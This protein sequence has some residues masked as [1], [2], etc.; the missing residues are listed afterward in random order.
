MDQL[1][2]ARIQ[3]ATTSIYHFLFVPITMGMAILVAVLHTRWFRRGTPELRGILRFFGGLML[4]SISV[5]VVTGLVQEFQF[6]LN[7]SAYSRF[8][9]DVFGAPLAMEGLAAFFLESTFLGLWLF[10]FN[11][12]PRRLHLFTAWMVAVGACLSALFIIAANSWMQNPRGYAINP[13]NGRAELTSIG[14][15]FTNPIFIW[16]YIH[17]LLVALIFG[18]GML[19]AVSA[20][21]LRRRPAVPAPPAPAAPIEAAAGAEPAASGTS[22]DAPVPVEP[23]APSPFLATAKLGLLALLIGTVLQFHVGGQ[24]GIN[25]TTYQP[26]KIAAA[27]ANWTTCQPCSFSMLQI[28]GWSA[29][30]PPTKIIE[31]PHL[32]SLL[33]TGTWDGQVQGLTPLN[34]QYQQ[35]YGPG[36]YV[37]NVFIQYWSMRV[38]AYIA[39]LVALFCVWGIWLW[40]RKKLATARLFLVVAS[41]IMVTP[42]FM[43]TAGWLLTESGR[44]P[45]IVQGLMLTKDGLSGSG[46]AGEIMISLGIVVVLYTTLGVIAAILMVRHARR[47][48]T[49]VPETAPPADAAAPTPSLTY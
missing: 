33:A 15:V 38:M 44:Q 9:G 24:L 7:W 3:F 23:V 18:G 42:F 6:G 4:I 48:L 13:D 26:M 45:W 25:E 19:L 41:W 30:D 17:V 29:D 28:G 34:E 31:I 20:W 27:E 21:Q 12:L 40:W 22:A 10:G 32:L 37:P 11:V 14:D 16:G 47:P 36:D 43:A 39:T 5:G 2:L 8:V 35:Q 1:D 46:S 49:P